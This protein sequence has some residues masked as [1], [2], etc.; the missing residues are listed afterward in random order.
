MS[1]VSELFYSRVKTA[2]VKQYLLAR[3]AGVDPAVLSRWLHGAPVNRGDARVIAI[4]RMLG[5]IE[6]ECFVDPSPADD[7]HVDVLVR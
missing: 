6:A 5:L 1:V 3:L 4:G 7:A 2:R